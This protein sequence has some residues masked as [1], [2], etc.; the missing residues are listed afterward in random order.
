LPYYICEFCNQP[1]KTHEFDRH[2]KEVHQNETSKKSDLERLKKVL[3]KS[4]DSDPTKGHDPLSLW[5]EVA[6][7]IFSET[8]NIDTA[9][10]SYVYDYQVK[11]LLD[12][13]IP[14][15][16]PPH[17]PIMMHLSGV[18]KDQKIYAQLLEKYRGTEKEKTLRDIV[19]GIP[20]VIV[21]RDNYSNLVAEWRREGKTTSDMMLLTIF[22][23]LH[24]MCHINGCGEKDADVKAAN[25]IFE[26][27]G[28]R[29]AIP[30]Y[31]IERWKEYEKFREEYRKK[32]ESSV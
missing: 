27:F 8:Q 29:I 20:V 9:N 19:K 31:E 30:D 15:T 32:R 17:P 28:M 18:I 10:Y 25:A 7:R 11:D 5:F 26:V 12:A 1:I 23:Y 4:K 13:A 3:N 24:E 21:C 2:R 14:T 6:K 22:F 16:R